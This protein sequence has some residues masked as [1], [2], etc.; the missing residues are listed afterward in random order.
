MRMTYGVRPPKHGIGDADIALAAGINN[1]TAGSI[2][3]PAEGD[4][5]KVMLWDD[6]K[7]LVEP[8]RK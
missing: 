5:I 4:D 2:F 3:A 7:P 6:I 1:V 8:F